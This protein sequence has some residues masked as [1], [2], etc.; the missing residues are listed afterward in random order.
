MAHLAATRAYFYVPSNEWGMDI[1]NEPISYKKG[2]AYL[3]AGFTIKPMYEDHIGS[4]KAINPTTMEVAWEVK[5]PAP[6]WGGVMA[7]AGGLVFTGMPEGQ[8]KAFDADTGEEL[9]SF[10]TGSGI[11]GQPVTWEQDGE[12]YIAVTSGWGG[13]VPLWGG[14]VAKQVKYLNQGGSVWVFRLPRQF[15]S[16]E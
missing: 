7:T 15:A 4:L 16:G 2:A 14:E 6:L 8:F 3:G 1:W 12:Q 9:W 5:N 10:Q 11:V 13:A